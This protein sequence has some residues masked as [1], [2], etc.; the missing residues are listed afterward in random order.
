MK[1]PVEVN[2]RVDVNS[3]TFFVERL[4]PGEKASFEI[5]FSIEAPEGYRWL[6]NDLGGHYLKNEETGEIID[7]DTGEIVEISQ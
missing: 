4:A 6:P 2:S 5:S 3:G 7:P 1:S